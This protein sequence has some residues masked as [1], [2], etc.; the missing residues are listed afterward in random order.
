MKYI[1]FL[2]FSINSLVAVCQGLPVLEKKQMYSDFDTLTKVLVEVSPQIP[3]RKKVTGLDLQAELI[4]LRYEIEKIETTVDFGALVKR[5]IVLCQ[6]GHTNLLWK[7]YYE[8]I[9]EFSTRYNWKSVAKE[10]CHI[11]KQVLSS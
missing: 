1:I 7:G 4:K 11:Y 8:N 6:D 10:Y 3:V 2:T 9:K 5:A